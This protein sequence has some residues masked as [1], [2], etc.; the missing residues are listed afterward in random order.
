MH[1]SHIHAKKPHH[2]ANTY[3][4]LSRVLTCFTHSRTHALKHTLTLTHAYS[5]TL[6]LAHTHSCTH[7]HRHT[8][9]ILT[10]TRTRMQFLLTHA[11]VCMHTLTNSVSS[12]FYSF[13]LQVFKTLGLRVAA[14]G[15]ARSQGPLYRQLSGLSNARAIV[16]LAGGALNPLVRSYFEDCIVLSLPC[17]IFFFFGNSAL[18]CVMCGVF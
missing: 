5:R 2:I 7:A 18:W 10:H 6:T 17:F 3:M 13:F 4:Y 15:P 11:H 1:A 9:A 12:Y 8:Y 14:M 16:S